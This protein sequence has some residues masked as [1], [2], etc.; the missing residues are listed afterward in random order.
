MHTRKKEL[1]ACREQANGNIAKI[2]HV[3]EWKETYKGLYFTSL[4][5]CLN[6]LKQVNVFLAF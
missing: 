2:E 5:A 4:I 1:K 3:L 6:R